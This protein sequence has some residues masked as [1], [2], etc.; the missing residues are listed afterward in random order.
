MKNIR[1]LYLLILALVIFPLNLIAQDCV[2][3]HELGD[4]MLDKQRGYKVY[5][6]SKSVSM[7]PLDTVELNIVFYGQKDYIL[8]F[9]AHKKM[10]PIH[11]TL[12]DPES[13]QV[14]YDNTNDRYI[15]SLGVGFD[16]T[17]SI[18]VTIQALARTSSENEVEHSVGC[19][20][21]LIQY[22]NYDAKKVNL[23]MQ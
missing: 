3:Y 21:L 8:S 19:V 17:K 10:Y 22:K 23:K 1:Y 15:E 7:N 5:S 13:R 20:G 11:F 6:Q 4:C 2:N 16:V 9:C 12:V 14:L 18:T